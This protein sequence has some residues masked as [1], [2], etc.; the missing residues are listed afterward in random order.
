MRRADL[1]QPFCDLGALARDTAQPGLDE[2]PSGVDPAM[3][4]GK[5]HRSAVDYMTAAAAVEGSRRNEHVPYPH[6]ISPGIHPEAFA[7]RPGEASE[8]SEPRKAGLC[9]G[10]GDETVERTRADMDH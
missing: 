10:D 1:H 6:A 2:D 3:A 4:I 8:Q 5:R 9:R 7:D